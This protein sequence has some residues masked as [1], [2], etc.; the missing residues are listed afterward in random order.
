[1]RQLLGVILLLGIYISLVYNPE[2]F[3]S[4]KMD[5]YQTELELVLKKEKSNLFM[6]ALQLD[7]MDMNEEGL[8]DED[9]LEEVYSLDREISETLLKIRDIESRLN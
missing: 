4:D 1:M 9:Y 3:K 8:S 7:E 2:N 5:P 6:L